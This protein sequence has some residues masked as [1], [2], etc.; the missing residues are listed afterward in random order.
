MPVVCHSLPHSESVRGSTSPYAPK[1]GDDGK[2]TTVAS[3]A[4]VSLSPASNQELEGRDEATNPERQHVRVKPRGFQPAR[5]P[6][7]GPGTPACVLNPL[8]SLQSKLCSNSQALSSH[9]LP[10]H[11][12]ATAAL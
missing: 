12:S 4:S 2:S 5:L 1:S 10:V 9:Y 6:R 3:D 8:W 11:A 7:P